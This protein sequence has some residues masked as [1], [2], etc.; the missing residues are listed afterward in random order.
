[1]SDVTSK[2]QNEMDAPSDKR[3]VKFTPKGLAFYTKT[4]QE[5]RRSKC[6]QAEGVW[7]KSAC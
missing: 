5:K 1:M 7:I 2:S 3:N 4:C 6:K